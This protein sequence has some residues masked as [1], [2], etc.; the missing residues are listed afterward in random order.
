MARNATA[1]K[2]ADTTPAL[3]TLID[4]LNSIR[5]RRRELDKK[6]KAVAEE[7]KAVEADLLAA[8]DA[9]G[10]EQS[11]GSSATATISENVVPQVEDWEKFHRFLLRNKAL[12]L[13][14]RRAAAAAY[15]EM[16][17]QRKGRAIPG[18]VSFTKR[19]INLRSRS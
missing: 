12:Y 1:A 2:A 11:R 13:L 6:L 3:G 16:L 19:T 8:L 10:I 9:Q 5:E 15:R 14:E 7:Y 17:E 18:V 4:N